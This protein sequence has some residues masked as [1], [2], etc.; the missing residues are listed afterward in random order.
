MRVDPIRDL[1]DI[2]NIKKLIDHD[3]RY[4]AIFTLG[5]STNLR[6]SDICALKIKNVLG[7]QTGSE[8]VLVE[9]KTKKQRRI[10]VNSEVAAAIQRLLKERF[11]KNP[12]TKED[13]FLFVGQRGV[14]RVP[15]V[16]KMV[17]SWCESIRIPGANF[18][19]HSM[20]KTFGY[21]LRTRFGVPIE[22]LQEMFN[23]SSSKDT[24]RYIGI[25]PEDIKAN[26]LKLKY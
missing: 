10:T 21:H 25:Q 6:V 23:H 20:R 22:E 3:A 26:Y 19:S 8:I 11:E 24:L 16:S 7:I 17:K 5:I 14:F 9:K 15:T 13:E 2:R 12:N 1:K 4:L 18:S